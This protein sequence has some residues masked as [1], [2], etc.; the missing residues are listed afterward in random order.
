[1]TELFPNSLHEID[2]D[3][4]GEVAYFDVLRDEESGSIVGVNL[5]ADATASYRVDVGFSTENGIEY[6]SDTAEETY[7]D[8]Q[9]ISDSWMQ[10]ERFLKIEVTSAAPAGETAKLYVA[11]GAT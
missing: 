7:N 1:M 9:S 10:A 6:F 5:E 2:I 8:T 3:E 11:A 4:V